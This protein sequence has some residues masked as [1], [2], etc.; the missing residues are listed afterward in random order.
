MIIAK[1][2]HFKHIYLFYKRV[3][4]LLSLKINVCFYVS[5]DVHRIEL[6]EQLAPRYQGNVENF[7][8]II[9]GIENESASYRSVVNFIKMIDNIEA[10]KP[11]MNAFLY[12]RFI[13]IIDNRLVEFIDDLS[14]FNSIYLI[15]NEKQIRNNYLNI[16]GNFPNIKSI[17]NKIKEECV[18]ENELFSTK[19]FLNNETFNQS[20][21]YSQ[22][23]KET[24]LKK[25]NESNLKK[26]FIHFCRYHYNGNNIELNFI[27]EIEQ[28]FKLDQ[29]IW[30]YTRY[31]FIRK[32]LNRALRTEE[33]DILYKMRWFIQALDYKIKD[34]SFSEIVYRIHYYTYDQF[35][36]LKENYTNC[37]LSF[38]TFLDCKLNRPSFIENIQGMET[39]LFRIKTK[40]GI[41][42][43]HLRFF[44]SKIEVLL[45][46]DNVYRIESIEEYNNH[47][48]HWW[49]VDI[50]SINKNDELLKDLTNNIRQEIEGPVV[51][52]QLGKLL[53][54]NND[55]YQVDYLANL[56]F[57]DGSIENNP[58]LLASLAALHHLLGSVDNQRCNYRSARIQFEKS[59]KIF[60]SFIPEF[61]QILSATYNNIGSMFYQEDQHEQAII[62]HQKALQCQLRSS[63]P[64]MEAIATY[65]G[66]I[67]AVYLDQEKYDQ[68]L[69]H[70]K[71]T[72]LILQQSISNE[73]SQ[74][75]AMIYDRIASIYW[76]M[77]KPNE[78]LS[79]YQKALQL[80]LKY[81]PENDHKISVSYFNLSTACAKLNQL[82]DAINY[83]EKSIKQL[84]KSVSSDH[85][86]VKENMDQ[87]E[88]L[89]RRKWLYKLYE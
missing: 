5:K 76:K 37:L 67:G 38:G 81:L 64:D 10:V 12:E 6:H 32:M 35:K 85:P 55:Y 79:F 56:L 50:T 53:L 14:Q 40:N 60:L 44:E 78:A 11:F 72:L 39:I 3:G 68:A 27:E 28:N 26:D 33:I 63:S 13:L 8:V 41:K 31:C 71:R 34:N 77:E 15:S 52:I 86:E 18:V 20:F 1:T 82:D 62:Y 75:L 59:L 74:S 83:A 58:T 54:L 9:V 70:Y 17:F 42:I 24:L 57:N 29:S 47:N 69:L 23:L 48:N 43:Q 45:P 2:I 65:S 66:N 46:F 80:E 73:E 51:L 87:L 61:N 36:T 88:N 7:V 4:F 25:D 84:L 49:N 21:C 16:R 30:W 22:L 89:R 19:F